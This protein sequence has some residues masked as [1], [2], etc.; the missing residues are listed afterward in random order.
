MMPH[1]LGFWL[2]L[3]LMLVVSRTQE[4]SWSA[5]TP[6][7]YQSPHMVPQVLCLQLN[8]KEEAALG[9]S[10]GLAQSSVVPSHN[11]P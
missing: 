5:V 4:L 10:Q 1:M 3:G 2:V 6:V 8:F 7:P 11:L 9:I